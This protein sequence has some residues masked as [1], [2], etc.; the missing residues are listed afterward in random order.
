MRIETQLVHGGRPFWIVLLTLTISNVSFAQGYSRFD[1]LDVENPN[2]EQP[3]RRR[4]RPA[5]APPRQ[6]APASAPVI[7][8]SA[9]PA[10]ALA[11]PVDTSATAGLIQGLLAKQDLVIGST[12]VNVA[13]LRRLY[14][15]RGFKPFFVRGAALAPLAGNVREM[16]SNEAEY[17][18]FSSRLYFTHDTESRMT[19]QDPQRL[20]EAEILLT[21]GY[22]SLCFD[23]ASGRINPKDKSQNLADIELTPPPPP[24]LELINQALGGDV[25]SMEQ[26]FRNLAPHT[27][28]YVALLKTLVALKRAERQGGW[29]DLQDRSVLNPG[30]S[31]PNV[32]PIR[33]R[34]V[35]M[36]ALPRDQR[37]NTSAI[38]DPE[39]AAGVKRLQRALFK[40]QDAVIGKDTYEIL[41]VP[42]ADRIVQTKA[43]LE[44]W[45][46]LPRELGNRFLFVDL[47]RQELDV[48]ENNE[49]KLT[50][51]VV[52][53]KDANGTPTMNDWVHEVIINP[54]WRPPRSIVVKEIIPAMLKDS[55]YLARNRMRVLS[56]NGEINPQSVDWSRY[57]MTNPPPYEFRQDHG[58]RNALGVLKFNLTNAHAIYMHDT[59]H[60]EAFN[61][62]IRY[63]SHGCIRLEKPFDLAAYLLADQGYDIGTVQD[64]VATDG[65]IAKPIKLRERVRV[66]IFGT[67]MVAHRNGVVAFGNDIYKQ[68]QRIVDAMNGVNSALPSVQAPSVQL[69]RET[70]RLQ[71]GM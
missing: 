20:A 46:L 69:D 62:S 42:L 13:R 63:L 51:R 18:G 70:V 60:K 2:Y 52:V 28:G 66:Y 8:A 38:Y 39:M 71:P 54:Y 17:H 33:V 23:M 61:R 53:G 3:V 26:G 4:P 50:M 47:G 7:A 56:R 6:T 27:T 48:M 21:N 10:A 45:R 11:V 40:S 22:T 5:T 67:T 36:G 37:D 65:N 30:V 59:D 64:A 57:S 49:R 15:L 29:P 14:V 35:D 1:E 31:H 32:Y 25:N 24:K 55:S 9:P 34:L 44:R 58:E 43:N 19:A 41:T 12:P 68:D 16:L